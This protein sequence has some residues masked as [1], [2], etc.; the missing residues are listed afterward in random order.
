[1][2][3]VGGQRP[4]QTPI[5]C[6]GC[7]GNHKYIDFPQKNGKVRVVH[8]VHQAETVEDMGNRVPRI[9]AALDNKQSKYQLDMIEVEGMINNHAFIVLIDLGAN[10]SYIDPRV[11]ESLQL[12]RSKHGKSWLVQLATG[13]K[14]KVTKLIKSFPVDMNGLSTRAE[15][16]VLPLGSYDCLIGMDW[17]DQHHAI[18]DC[19]NKAFTCLDEEGNQRTVQGIPR[20]VVVREISTMQVKKCYRKG[21]QLFAAHVEEASKDEV[22]KIEYHAVLKDF[23]DVF[24]EVARLPLNKDID[25]SVNL[26]LGA[27]RVSKDPYR[28]ST[29]ELKE[30]QLQLE[31]LLKRGYIR[32]SVSPWGTPV[33]FVKKKDGTLRLCIDFR[34]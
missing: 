11:V 10:H 9:Y 22:S 27:T 14:R 32:P 29:P 13:T 25:F 18:L 4:R 5:Q 17:L 16:N 30:L 12:F 1:M 2:V 15:L 34:Q 8:N 20:V 26:M 24:Q 19:R 3:E 7:Q 23:E 31:E 21:C 28:M 33:L 6:W